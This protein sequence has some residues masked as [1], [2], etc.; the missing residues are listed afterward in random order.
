M[1][2]VFIIFF[3]GFITCILLSKSKMSLTT[4]LNSN[5]VTNS[6][7]A[8]SMS[9]K[10]AVGCSPPNEQLKL[11]LL[12]LVDQCLTAKSHRTL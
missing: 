8:E 2:I 11:M 4:L 12:A 6:G 9:S 3:L 1:I 5:Y 10:P 7:D